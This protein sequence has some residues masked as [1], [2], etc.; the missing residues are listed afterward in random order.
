[1]KKKAAMAA[2]KK[3]KP[4]Q[5][6]AKARKVRKKATASP[7]APVGLKALAKALPSLAVIS[8]PA[9]VP[10][11]LRMDTTDLQ[12]PYM[13]HVDGVTKLASSFSGECEFTLTSGTHHA[14]WSINHMEDLWEHSM[15]LR[16]GGGAPD[17]LERK[18][19][20]Q[21]DGPVTV[22]VVVLAAS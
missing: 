14:S 17:V 8:V 20:A 22:T 15:S 4:V 9:A 5:K 19:K 7:A 1:M 6:K 21:G 18:S 12:V 3:Q 2:R 13:V 10:L 11:K 16:K